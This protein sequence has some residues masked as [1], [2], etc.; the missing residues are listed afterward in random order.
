VLEAIASD[1]N[2]GVGLRS[3][4]VDAL[5]EFGR[6]DSLL[7]LGEDA[8]LDCRVRERAAILLEQLGDLEHG[9]RILR[10]VA[11]DVSADAKVRESALH[12]IAVHSTADLA[13]LAADESV[14]C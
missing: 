12:A 2:V 7:R 9:S 5:G 6:N 11:R 8:A 10:E 1:R 13:D 3:R 14:N 4:A